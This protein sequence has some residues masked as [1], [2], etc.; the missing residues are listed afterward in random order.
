MKLPEII[1]GGMGVAISDW[2]LARAVSLQGH[3]GV[4]SGTGI[5]QIMTSRLMEGDIEGH[6][7]R[8]LSHFPFQGPVRRILSRYY[9]SEPENP[10]PP[11][12]R[13]TMWTLKPPKTLN[14]LTVIANF[15]EV[16]LAKEGHQNAVG[17]N[18]LEKLQ[19]PTMASLY[20]AM[21]AEIDFV[22]M[23]AGIPLQIPGILDKLADH[24]AVSYRI[25]T[26]G[27]AQEDDY[28]LHFD[29]QAIFP[30]VVEKI[31]RLTRPNFLPIIS[32]VVL[33]K[34]LIKRA[35]GKIDGFVIEAPTAGGHNA[36][37]RG[38]LHLD[39]GGEPIYGEKDEVD[40]EKIKQLG[41]PFWLAGGY[42]SP[43]QLQDAL[44]AGAT[45]IQVGTSFA[46]CAESGMDE[47]LK[48]RIIQK[49]LDKEIKVRT[50]PIVSPTGYPFKV[51]QLEGTLS[52]PE[53]GRNRIRL[54]DV[55]MLRNPY[56]RADGK[57]GYRCPAEP[58][59]L[60]LKKGGK[61][62]DTVGKSCLCN[63]LFATARYAQHRKD[64]YVE[65]PIVTSGDGLEGIGKYVKPGHHSY[66]A[67]DV[68]DYLTG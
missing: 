13:P 5:G 48:S 25:D 50:D 20:G 28:H 17:L 62:E 66:T 59:K 18:L 9:V 31:G 49:V 40:L 68:L 29:P 64:G 3:L 16:F 10:Q 34:A 15:V 21:L 37:P 1:Q 33:A 61:P 32:S 27:A 36:P 7:R 45:G 47:K 42:D 46:Y 12:K 6:I 43:E 35:T 24:Q 26:Q 41:L 19:M 38:Q 14:E 23:G 39:E 57:V 30:D 54:C 56:R 55:G 63:N 53:I 51:V 8:A 11:Y 22:I 2:N 58:V 4:V 52:D 60:Y 44:D 67:Q 65:P